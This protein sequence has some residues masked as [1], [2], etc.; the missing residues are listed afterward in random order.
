MGT[1]KGVIRTWVYK[2]IIGK[3]ILSFK[4]TQ[5]ITRPRVF[6][7]K[8]KK[9]LPY[10]IKLIYPTSKYHSFYTSSLCY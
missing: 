7:N 3:K 1:G 6:A 2:A 4:K 5:V 10:K 9:A 8:I